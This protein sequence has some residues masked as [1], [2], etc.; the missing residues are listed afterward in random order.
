MAAHVRAIELD[1]L[2]GGDDPVQN[3]FG[4]HGIRRLAL[5]NVRCEQPVIVS[6]CR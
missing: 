2:G 3:G 5:A 6:I 4:N 1:Q